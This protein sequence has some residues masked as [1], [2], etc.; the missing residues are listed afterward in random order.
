MEINNRS[1]ISVII[2]TRNRPEHLKECLYCLK[3]QDYG[4]FEIIVVDS[5]TDMETQKI[6]SVYAD[7]KYVRFYDGRNTA[8]SRN[9]GINVSDGEIVVFIDDDCNVEDGWLEGIA[10]GFSNETIGGVGGRV[11]DTHIRYYTDDI[12]KVGRIYPDGAVS[13]FHNYDS[14]RPIFVDYIV[15]T[16]MAF[17][18]RILTELGGFDSVFRVWND[19]DISMRVKNAGYSIL[20]NPKA[21]LQHKSAKREFINRDRENFRSLYVYIRSH[22]YC[23]FKNGGFRFPYFKTLFYW[24][25]LFILKRSSNHSLLRGIFLAAMQLSG[26]FTGLMIA[27]KARFLE[28]KDYLKFSEKIRRAYEERAQKNSKGGINSFRKW[29]EKAYR[30]KLVYQQVL[31]E[32][33]IFKDHPK[34][35]EELLKKWIYPQIFDLKKI[36]KKIKIRQ[37]C[38]VLEIGSENSHLSAYL[39]ETGFFS[40]GIDLSLD[41]LS[42]GAPAI[43]KEIG[44]A[45]SP[46][47]IN[48][49][50]ERLPFKENS[51]DVVFCFSVLHHF[52][53]LSMLAG[54]INRI[55]KKEG[56]F[57]FAW[58]PL[59]SIFGLREILDKGEDDSIP[60]EL[61]YGI[62]EGKYSFFEYRKIFKKYFSL[63]DWDFSKEV[64]IRNLFKKYRAAFF[65]PDLGIEMIFKKI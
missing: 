20:S 40:I 61:L 60:S 51:F 3:K 36:L 11:V 47:L 56:I 14:D 35:V 44:C 42:M 30:A 34:D 39:R 2:V 41:T 28:K 54:E 33:I 46:F 27:I 4:N 9:I 17:R 13:G 22:S 48:A 10:E 43:R 26:A 45:N 49:D 57:F 55:L 18:K 58:E 5:S 32:K 24:K 31:G 1:L 23:M 16:N 64:N 21:R 12:A 53:D 63:L 7:I 37:G 15:G 59:R 29:G 38:N 19:I 52:P 62:Y 50:A 65:N 6:V 8:V 25:A